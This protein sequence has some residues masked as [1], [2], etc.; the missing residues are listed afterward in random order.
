MD[1]LRYLVMSRPD[2]SKSEKQTPSNKYPTMSSRVQAELEAI[3]KPKT[4][5]PFGDY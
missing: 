3:R 4:K 2:P 5:D 1:A